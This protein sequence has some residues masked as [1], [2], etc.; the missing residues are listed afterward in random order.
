MTTLEASVY[1]SM[2]IVVVLFAVFL[3]L[4][5]AAKLFINY[6]V[7]KSEKLADKDEQAEQEN[8]PYELYIVDEG[9]W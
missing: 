4:M 6:R 1:S 8:R 3:V 5:V 7:S 2:F 9:D